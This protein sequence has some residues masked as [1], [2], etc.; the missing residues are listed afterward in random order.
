VLFEA[1]AP[2]IFANR[3]EK[4]GPGDRVEKF[5]SSKNLSPEFWPRRRG[6]GMEEQLD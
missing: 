4:D 2:Q 3:S 6:R 1:L 5:F